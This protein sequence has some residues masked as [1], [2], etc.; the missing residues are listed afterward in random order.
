MSSRVMPWLLAARPKTLPAAIVPVLV[1]AACAAHFGPL[2]WGPTAAALFGALLLQI[3]SNFANDVYDHEKGADTAARVGPTRAVQ[4]GWISPRA[5]KRAMA[6]V[7]ALATVLGLYLTW[8]AG[9]WIVVIGGASIVAAIAYTGGPYPLGY[10]GLGEVFVMIFFG[11]V[12]VCGTAF[13]NLG[14]VPELALYCAVPI[15]AL[16]SAILVVNNVRDEATDRATGKRTLV[17]RFGRRLGLL[18]YASLVVLAYVTPLLVYGRGVTGPGVLLPLVSVPLAFV[19]W[20]RLLR[21][22]GPSLNPVL[23]QT[24]LLLLLYG[25]LASVGLAWEARDASL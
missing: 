16:A 15:G 3:G 25:V 2:R 9:P 18:E 21:E 19:V 4:A 17:A 8:V 20:R 6:L 12:A 22:R 7:F 23:E 5:M 24:A 10:H 14:V 11:F 1:G 13:V